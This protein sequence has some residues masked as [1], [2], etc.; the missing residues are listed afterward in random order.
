MDEGLGSWMKLQLRVLKLIDLLVIF[1]VLFVFLGLKENSCLSGSIVY[2][3]SSLTLRIIFEL[4]RIGYSCG[5]AVGDLEY[6]SRKYSGNC[7]GEWDSI[8][9]G[10]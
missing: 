10:E 2:R 3:G 7:M 9:L 5:F 8:E 4:T 1:V 6:S